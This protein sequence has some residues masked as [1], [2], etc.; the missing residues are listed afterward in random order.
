MKLK[1]LL[2][3]Y[4]QFTEGLVDTQT[5]I[6][7]LETIPPDT[8]VEEQFMPTGPGFPP[9]KKDTTATQR[10]EELKKTE[11]ILAARV[12]SIKKSLIE[13]LNGEEQTLPMPIGPKV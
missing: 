10:I 13:E 12:K 2:K 5:L 6:K 7:A 1:S 9:T 4:E 8:I 11:L 3:L